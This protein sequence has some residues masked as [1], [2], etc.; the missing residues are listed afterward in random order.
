MVEYLFMDLRREVNSIIVQC[1][2][3]LSHSLCF[4][5]EMERKMKH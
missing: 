3:S 4:K 1:N 2:K 5:V